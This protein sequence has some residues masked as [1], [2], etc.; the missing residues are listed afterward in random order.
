M[1]WQMPLSELRP[2]FQRQVEAL[3][4]K[5]VTSLQPKQVLGR[6]LNGEMF[7]ELARS[8]VTA[9]NEGGVPVIS[10]AL[11]RAVKSQ[12]TVRTSNMDIY[13]SY[14]TRRLGTGIFLS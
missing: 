4:R 11:E 12:C 7:V 3:K 6:G 13:A 8:Y 5:V 14:L 9:M 1:G 10:T 2:E